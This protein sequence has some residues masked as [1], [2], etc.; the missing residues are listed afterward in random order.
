MSLLGDVEAAIRNCDWGTA[1]RLADA[2]IVR[3]PN[4]ARLHYY[5]GLSSL[6]LGDLERSLDAL[7]RS[8]AL[9]D[10]DW[11]A[12]TA[13]AQALDLSLIHI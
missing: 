3:H 5:S 11:E 8:V 7:R 12:G 9:N 1:R 10:M 6:R 2:K 4:Q 13:L